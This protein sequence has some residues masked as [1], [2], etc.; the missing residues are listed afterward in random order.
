MTTRML[1]ATLLSMAGM[2]GHAA[3]AS[4]PTAP[5]WSLAT[6]DEPVESRSAPDGSLPDIET[7]KTRVLGD[8]RAPSAGQRI[9]LPLPQGK[10]M[11]LDLQMA[12]TS[13]E[14][15]VS[16]H[17]I[18]ASGH[19][20]ALLTFGGGGVFGVLDSEDGRYMVST[21]ATG[22]WLMPLDDPRLRLNGCGGGLGEPPVLPADSGSARGGPVQIDVMFLYTPDMVERYPGGLLAA[23]IAHVIAVGNQ[24][25]VD[26]ETDIVVRLVHSRQIPYLESP[27]VF[28]ALNGMRDAVSGV[29]V[30]GLEGLDQLRAEHGADIVVLFW[31][32]DLET[33]GACGVAFLPDNSGG[34]YDPLV[35]VQVTNDGVSNW[36]VCD[37]YVFVHELGHNLGALHQRFPGEPAGSNYAFVV[38]GVFNTIMGSFGSAQADRFRRIGAFSNPDILCAGVPCG[39]TVPGEEADNAG[40][41]D[42]FAPTIAGYAATTV[43]GTAARPPASSPDSDG[44]GVSDWLDLF[45]FDRYDDDPPEQP[46]SPP[47]TPLPVLP[48]TGGAHQFELLVTNSGN[49]Q[50]RAYSLDGRPIRVVAQPIPI[51]PRPAISDFSDLDVDAE[52][53]L[54]LLASADVRRFSRGDGRLLDVF[55]NAAQPFPRQLLTGFSRAMGF[56]PDRSQLVVLGDYAVE[57][58]ALD[59]TRVSVLMGGPDP[60]DPLTWNH[61]MLLPL[62]AFTFGP[63]DRFYLTEMRHKR[64][65]AFDTITGARVLPDVA[66]SAGGLVQDPWDLVIGPDGWLYVADGNSHR[67]LRFNPATPGSGEVFVNAGAGGLSFA[68]A[69]A[70]GPD[71]ALYVVSRSN[72]RILRYDG[73]TGNFA[74]VV[75]DG[76][77]LDRP[78]T[79]IITTRLDLIFADGFEQP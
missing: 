31:P 56:S 33:R 70:F 66:P 2:V 8:V 65:M 64:I 68:R 48:G 36:S 25:L 43:A 58:Y 9:S 7:I 71:G 38:E 13:G 15:I 72:N 42:G 23:R 22:T 41:L 59:G 63:G 34:S 30:P 73:S 54:Y 46:P 29:T 67:V 35:G 3:A 12:S 19:N 78:E 44:D 45:P 16:L 47:F 4:A 28:D 32:M 40:T 21:D 10:A 18:D 52:G 62:R 55:L 27:S 37:D 49:D 5:L 51:D 24:A 11:N 79:M 26:S 74:G 1:A 39:S 75:V 57:R 60:E 6:A 61:Q 77:G 14:G 53:R 20:K 76:A 50:V 17:G 69:L